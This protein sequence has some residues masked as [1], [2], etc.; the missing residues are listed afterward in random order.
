[1]VLGHRRV[2]KPVPTIEEQAELQTRLGRYLNTMLVL[3]GDH[4]NV[5]LNPLDPHCGLPPLLRNTELGRDMLAQDVVLKHVVAS[6]T[7]PCSTPHGQAFWSEADES[8]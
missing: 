8:A 1:M 3:S 6:E 5:D 7:H 2:P 4:L